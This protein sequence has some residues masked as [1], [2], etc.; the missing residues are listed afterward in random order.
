MSLVTRYKSL[1]EELIDAPMVGSVRDPE[2]IG[3]GW[4]SLDR[5]FREIIG[6]SFTAQPNEGVLLRSST[7]PISV[8]YAIVSSIWILLGRDD[9]ATLKPFNSR[10]SNFSIDGF[11]LSGAFGHRLR[12]LDGDQLSHALGLMRNDPSTRR[13]ICFIGRADDLN[14]DLRD[15]PC[16]S[17]VQFL[18]RRG[19]L[20]AVVYMRSQSFF[21]VFPYDV[22]NFRY[23]QWYAASQLGVDVG[24]LHMIFGS[25]HIY[26]EELGK[27]TAF[28]SESTVISNSVPELPWA[29]LSELLESFLDPITGRERLALFTRQAETE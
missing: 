13:A 3:S 4:G 16:A 28:L 8:E 18:L 29:S 1:L 7:R 19:R 21:G 6:R 22:V 15:F 5:P 27:I 23:I 25:L 12:V 14:R 24:R 9:L 10:G 26:E 11:T 20:D 17:S 2:S